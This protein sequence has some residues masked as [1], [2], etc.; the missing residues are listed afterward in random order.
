MKPLDLWLA[1]FGLRC[2]ALV[3][4][5]LFAFL[6]AVPTLFN[7][8]TDLADLGAALVGLTAVVG[9]ALW[10]AALSREFALFIRDKDDE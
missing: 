9:G 3:F 2:C 6:F 8:H 10:G 7:L 1:A 4:L 5:E